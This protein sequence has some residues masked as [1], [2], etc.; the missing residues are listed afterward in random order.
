M[1]DLLYARTFIARREFFFDNVAKYINTTSSCGNLAY[2]FFYAFA[3]T[4]ITF[5]RVNFL[6]WFCLD[7][8]FTPEVILCVYGPG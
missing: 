6:V 5:E 8:A 3:T 4:S 7:I 1:P 2:E